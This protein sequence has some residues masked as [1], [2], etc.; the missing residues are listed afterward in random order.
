MFHVIHALSQLGTETKV[1]EFD[2]RVGACV[3]EQNIHVFKVPMDQPL[4]VDLFHS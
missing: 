4:V 2:F 1:R 3:A